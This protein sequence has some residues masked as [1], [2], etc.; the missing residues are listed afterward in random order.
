MYKKLLTRHE[1]LQSKLSECSIAGKKSMNNNDEYAVKTWF[2]K[3]AECDRAGGSPL[4]LIDKVG[5]KLDQCHTQPPPPSPPPPPKESLWHENDISPLT[6]LSH[7]S[8]PH[9]SPPQRCYCTDQ[10]AGFDTDRVKVMPAKCCF[11][12]LSSLKT[13]SVNWMPIQGL[14]SVSKRFYLYTFASL[15]SRSLLYFA[16]YSLHSCSIWPVP[17]ITTMWEHRP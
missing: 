13:F 9:S 12:N 10:I 5:Y 6:I 2:Y 17:G 1:R 3:E 16:W 15:S 8:T 7:H 14:L 4:M 11:W